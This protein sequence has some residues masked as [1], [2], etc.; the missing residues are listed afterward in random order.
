MAK[1]TKNI[2]Y[3]VQY[4]YYVLKP[5]GLAPYQ[6]DFKNGT[7]KTSIRNFFESFAIT[8]LWIGFIILQVQ[9]SVGNTYE[10]GVQSNLLEKLW[11][12][13]Y[14]LQHCIAMFIIIFHTIKS[15]S[16]GEFLNH[17]SKFDTSFEQFGWRFRVTQSCNLIVLLIFFTVW[18]T[19]ACY[20]YITVYVLR[21]YDEVTDKF[22][23]IELMVYIY[24]TEFYLMLT[25]QFILSVC[26]IYIRLKALTRNVRY[27]LEQFK[28]TLNDKIFALVYFYQLM[29]AKF[30]QVNFIQPR[31]RS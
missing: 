30:Y 11:K 5:F 6:L 13:Q 28:M 16:I 23:F 24:I 14:L 4:F 17:I 21:I 27:D 26:A 25:L 1:I 22:F 10:S 2:Y 29:N 9:S 3:S 20:Q 8:I 18:A 7:F 12:T 19:F 15:K 31:K